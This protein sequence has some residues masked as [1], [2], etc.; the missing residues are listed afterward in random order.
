[1][2][3]FLMQTLQ[4]IILMGMLISTVFEDDWKYMYNYDLS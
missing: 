4:K 2:M 3:N 1:M